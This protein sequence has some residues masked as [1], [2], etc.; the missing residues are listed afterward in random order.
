MAI[1]GIQQKVE[2]RVKVGIWIWK[3]SGNPG[4]LIPDLNNIEQMCVNHC[5]LKH[6][7]FTCTYLF[8]F[9][10]CYE[11]NSCQKLESCCLMVLLFNTTL[12]I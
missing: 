3:L 1:I 2:S 5:L 11:S 10:A 4:I 6:C 12:V 7:V 9:Q 8:S